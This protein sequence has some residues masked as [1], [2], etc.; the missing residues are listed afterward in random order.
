[1]SASH[2]RAEIA[3]L[4]AESKKDASELRKELNVEIGFDEEEIFCELIRAFTKQADGLYTFRIRKIN[5]DRLCSLLECLFMGEE[6]PTFNVKKGAK[7][8]VVLEQLEFNGY[9]LQ[10]IKYIKCHQDD[11]FTVILRSLTFEKAKNI[12][13]MGFPLE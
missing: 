7:R 12:L 9:P 8:D 2:L 13:L 5:L 10:F 11:T 4:K 3:K 1:M 6:P